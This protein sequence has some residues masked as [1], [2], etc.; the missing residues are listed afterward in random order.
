MADV[1]ILLTADVNKAN[2]AERLTTVVE[3][4]LASLPLKKRPP[5]G[6]LDMNY[7]YIAG[8]VGERNTAAKIYAST[9]TTEAKQMLQEARREL[10][11][12][13][14]VAKNKWLLHV[15]QASNGSSLPG[16]KDRKDAHAMWKLATK[17]KRGA[18]KW[19]PWLRRNIV[20]ANGVL[21]S[22]P[23]GNAENFGAYYDALFTNDVLPNGPAQALC[24][25]M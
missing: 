5:S 9:K 16:G 21:A 25:Q 23:E 2:S 8:S 24:A 13:K 11:L 1:T 15:L 18:K 22:D 4:A 3:E 17:L 14:K 7:E 20:D 10:K 6:W 19:K 12:R